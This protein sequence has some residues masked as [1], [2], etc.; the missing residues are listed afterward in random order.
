MS[1]HK[2]LFGSAEYEC[3]L[4]AKRF[5]L[6]YHNRR[7]TESGRSYLGDR[8]RYNFAGAKANFHRHVNKC[9]KLAHAQ[10]GGK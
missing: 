10:E 7:L 1:N 5:P 3:G 6:Y 9:E 2:I 4:C 8:G